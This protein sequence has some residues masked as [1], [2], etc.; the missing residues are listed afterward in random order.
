MEMVRKNLQLVKKRIKKA[1]ERVGRREGEVLVLGAT[2]TRSVEE[3]K[4]AVEAGLRCI[5]ESRV[6]EMMG[7][8]DGLPSDLRLDFIGHLQRN[9]VKPVVKNCFLIHSVDSLRLAQEIGKVAGKQGK[10][11]KILL[12][13]NIAGE[14]TK[15][16]FSKEELEKVM[17]EVLTL[18]RLNVLGLMT[19]EPYRQDPEKV[20]GV[21]K[22]LRELRD[23]LKKKFKVKLPELSMGMSQ[24]FEVAAEEGATIVRS[25]E[26]IFG[27]RR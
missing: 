5:G 6:Q 26:G 14:E 16:G 17:R 2:K 22:S 4:E 3:I 7:K 19:M 25:G 11:Q 20:R 23:S 8:I 27:P 18:K 24:D 13:V 12:E 1:C 10:R 21:F 9:K 15:H